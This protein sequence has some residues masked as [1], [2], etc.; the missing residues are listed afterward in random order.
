[1][2]ESSISEFTLMFYSEVDL[3]QNQVCYEHLYKSE[4]CEQQAGK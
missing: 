4:R 3:L 1:M 2:L